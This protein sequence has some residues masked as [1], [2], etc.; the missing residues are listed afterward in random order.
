MCRLFWIIIMAR[1]FCGKKS[2][3]GS[4]V[5]YGHISSF[6]LASM[7]AI[8]FFCK[9]SHFP[10]SFKLRSFLHW[11]II[12]QNCHAY[13]DYCLCV[14]GVYENMLNTMFK[15]DTI[16][17]LVKYSLKKKEKRKHHTW[18]YSIYFTFRYFGQNV[19]CNIRMLRVSGLTFLALLTV[20]GNILI[21]ASY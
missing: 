14:K 4:S 12:M 10:V 17:K 21:W 19:V 11:W 2:E 1:T 6:T 7:V 18:S 3:V 8:S 9:S 20:N 5:S 13:D 15:W 16:C